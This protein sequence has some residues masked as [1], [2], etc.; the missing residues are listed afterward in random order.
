MGGQLSKRGV[1]STVRTFLAVELPPSLKAGLDRL[2]SDFG[3]SASLKWSA[4]SLLHI[5]VRFLGSVHESRMPDVEAA[6]RAAAARVEPFHLSLAGLGAFPNER[7]PRVIWVGLARN[8]GYEELGRLFERVE[9]ELTAREFPPEERSFSPHITLARA[10]DTAGLS[11]KREIGEDLRRAQ[12]RR[13]PA[14]SWQVQSLLV[15][16]SDLGRDGPRYT[17]L[18]A[19][20]LGVGSIESGV[21]NQ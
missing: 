16:R 21:V 20:P 10:R 14:G 18:A 2:R 5:T 8:A 17:A 13:Q 4:S 19:C 11:D 3:D 6:A 1:G 15:M 7:V 9:S 12:S